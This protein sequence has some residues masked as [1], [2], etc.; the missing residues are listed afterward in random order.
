MMDLYQNSK[1]RTIFDIELDLNRMVIHEAYKFEFQE[2]PELV[3]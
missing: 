3:L 2:N 1:I